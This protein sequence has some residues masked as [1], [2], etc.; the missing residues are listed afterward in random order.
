MGAQGL[1]IG[2]RRRKGRIS[3]SK[4]YR[5]GHGYGVYGCRC[6][7][8][9]AKTKTKDKKERWNKK[10]SNLVLRVWAT[11]A[12]RTSRAP[13][14]DGSRIQDV[15]MEEARRHLNR[16]PKRR[17]KEQEK[18]EKGNQKDREDTRS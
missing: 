13:P 7:E 4:R 16:N 15:E 9:S 11:T 2:L 12:D 5:Y 3:K 8:V 10:I 1:R 18:K 6:T 14:I 17:K